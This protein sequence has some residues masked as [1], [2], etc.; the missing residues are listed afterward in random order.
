MGELHV[1][2][3]ANGTWTN[4]IFVRTGNQAATW[5]TALVPLTSYV[6]QTVLFRFR[7]ITG[8]DFASDLALDGIEVTN[9]VDVT[10]PLNAQ[11]IQ[12]FPN[13]GNGLYQ[14]Q[15]S[16]AANEYTLEVFDLSGRMLLQQ[17][18][19]AATGQLNTSIDLSMYAAGT[20]MLRISTGSASEFVK[21][22]KID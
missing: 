15:I 6:G 8:N 4:D 10:E 13:P 18:T 12:V 9:S 11:H 21:L 20:Y 16:G 5:Q 1:D 22:E 19:P 7:G 17:T 3:Y 2:I 14:V